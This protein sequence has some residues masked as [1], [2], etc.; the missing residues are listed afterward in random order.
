[1]TTLAE[2]ATTA[3]NARAEA[4]FLQAETYA[5]TARQLVHA[6][7]HHLT[8]YGDTL[9]V[10]VV[11]PLAAVDAVIRFDCGHH[12]DRLTG[13]TTGR[14]PDRRRPRPGPRRADRPRLLRH[15]LPADPLVTPMTTPPTTLH[16]GTRDRRHPRPGAA[17]RRQPGSRPLARPRRRHPRLRPAR[18]AH[19]RPAHRREGHRPDRRHPPHHHRPARRRH[20]RALRRPPRLRVPA[21][22]G[23]LPGRHL[24]AHPRRAGRR[25]RRPRHRGRASGRVRHPHRALLRTRPHPHGE[26]RRRA[27]CGRVGCAATSPCARTAASSCAPNATPRTT[28]GWGARSAWTATTTPHTWSGTA[29][30]GNCGA[31]P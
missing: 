12:P 2:P 31:A 16:R 15:R 5:L 7:A 13:W 6:L 30:P 9:A 3:P 19:R 18:P 14:T 29:G 20:L 24:P 26:P 27:R 4:V 1:M 11:D 28:R 25:Q 17:P 10:T 23:D 8:R 21:V 22:C